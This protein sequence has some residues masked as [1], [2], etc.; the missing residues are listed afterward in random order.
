MS[1]DLNLK[2]L[3]TIDGKSG[4]G[5]STAANGLAKR[6][7]IPYLSS[8]RLYRIAAKKLIENKPRNIIAFLNGEISLL[9]IFFLNGY[10]HL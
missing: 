8:G 7:K 10:L 5:K 3:Y 2:G 1:Q 9:R 6:L 4:S